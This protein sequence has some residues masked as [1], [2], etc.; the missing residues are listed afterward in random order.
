MFNLK[1]RKN[2]LPQKIAQLFPPQKS[3]GPS[4]IIVASFSDCTL[5]YLFMIVLDQKVLA[6]SLY[7]TFL[8]VVFIN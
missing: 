2:I 8:I 4:L 5:L 7:E 1:V 6:C 3:N